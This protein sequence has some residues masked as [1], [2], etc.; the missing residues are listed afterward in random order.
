MVMMTGNDDQEY[1]QDCFEAGVSDYV[2]KPAIIKFV[3]LKIH[4]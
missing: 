2:T 1:M 4:R 3:W